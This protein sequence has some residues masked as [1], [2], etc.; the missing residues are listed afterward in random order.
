MPYSGS[1]DQRI[2]R[3]QR[4]QRAQRA[5]VGSAGSVG[6]GANMKNRQKANEICFLDVA[7]PK[8]FQHLRDLTV[9]V[10]G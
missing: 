5:E 2:Q 1:A 6:R 8:R 4:V 10:K 3:V 7:H 9:P